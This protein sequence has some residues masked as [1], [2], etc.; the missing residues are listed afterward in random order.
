MVTVME[1]YIDLKILV[2]TSN[3]VERL[4]SIAKYVYTP[5]RQ[6]MLPMNLEML[7]FLRVNEPIWT[8]KFVCEALSED[9]TKNVVAYDIKDTYILRY[10]F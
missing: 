4:F 5:Q 9:K 1:D 8:K 10:I 3:C 6:S 7:L 2:P